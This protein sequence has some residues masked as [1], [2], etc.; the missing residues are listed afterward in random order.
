M[1]LISLFQ[2][3]GMHDYS[4]NTRNML[5]PSRKVGC[6]AQI[7]ISYVTVYINYSGLDKTKREKC[8]I[9]N[10]IKEDEINGR[11][12]TENRI[13]V[14]LPSKDLHTNHE[15][16]LQSG[17]SKR[18]HPKVKEKINEMVSSGITNVPLVR[19]NLR[20][21]V[22]EEFSDKSRRP[23]ILDRSFYPLS[24]DIRNN[25]QSCLKQQSFGSCDQD[26]LKQQIDQW[27]SDRKLYFR[28]ASQSD[29]GKTKFLLVHQEHWQQR[30][31]NMYRNTICLLDATYKTTKYALPLFMLVVKTN[32]DYIPIAEFVTEDEV[33][34][35][36]SE[37]LNVIKNWNPDWN[38]SYFMSDFCE[39]QIRALETT[40]PLWRVFLCSFHREQAWDRW[41]RDG[42][43][44]LLILDI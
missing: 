31:L 29:E 15:I 16:T 33:S 7:F 24:K 35:T 41:T 9:V 13:Y 38:P 28:P 37:A 10:Q 34:D 21:F 32:V 25:I 14:Q 6:E 12:E 42:K 39:A 22:E 20:V 11:S 3:A 44:L 23:S 30:L 5:N 36:I 43:V 18:I 17:L 19:K 40:F 27:K 4:K 26:E 1:W 8:A 2:V